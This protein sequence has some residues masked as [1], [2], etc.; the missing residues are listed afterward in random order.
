[1][2]ACVMVPEPGF[3]QLLDHARAMAARPGR[4][5]LG[6]TGPPGSGKST[7]AEMLVEHMAPHAAYVPL[8]GFHLAH[9]VLEELRRAD[10]K[11]AP[12]TFDAPGYIALL[13]RLHDP[14]EGVIYAPKF[15][16]EIE[17][18]IAHAIPVHPDVP[19][20]ITEGNY[21]LVRS[22]P[23]DKIRELLDEV[24]YLDLDEEI[25]SRR[26]IDRHLSFGRN[27]DEARMRA[28]GSDQRNAELIEATR[29]YATRVI[30]L[31]NVADTVA[32]HGGR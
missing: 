14:A 5:I 1:L 16:R 18:S 27:I 11:G 21:L 2:Y 32:R 26:L 6:I 12:D 29:Q 25:R 28:G 20:V 22:E 30:S 23:W 8:D 7:L 3:Q 19:L 31:A 15:V 10:R 17:D 9:Q 24:W 13:G 4:T